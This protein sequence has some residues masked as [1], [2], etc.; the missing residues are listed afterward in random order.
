MFEKA[1]SY[2]GYAAMSLSRARLL[3]YFIIIM[4]NVIDNRYWA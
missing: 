4:F 2:K 1:C 3:Y